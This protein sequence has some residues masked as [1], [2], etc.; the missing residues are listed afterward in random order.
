LSAANGWAGCSTSTTGA[1]HEFAI[2][3]WHTTGDSP[4]KVAK[5]TGA[6]YFGTTISELAHSEMS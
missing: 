5:I 4:R 2:H 3:F 6:P 1:P